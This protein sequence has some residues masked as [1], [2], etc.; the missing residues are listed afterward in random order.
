M[1]TCSAVDFL[2]SSLNE[3]VHAVQT[4]RDMDRLAVRR[5]VEHRFASTRMVDD[6]L[7]VHHRVV[8]LDRTRRC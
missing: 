7:A 4:S 8:E 1:S 6:Y 2:V 3:A 5:S